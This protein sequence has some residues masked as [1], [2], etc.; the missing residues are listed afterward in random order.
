M[1]LVGE[2]RDRE[3]ISA[4]VTAAETGALVFATLHTYDAASTL[5]RI[6]S[7]YPEG[8]QDHIRSALAYVLRGVV[9]QTLLPALSGGRVAAYE[10]WLYPCGIKQPEGRRSA[11][12]AKL[13][14]AA[15]NT[16]C[17]TSKHTLLN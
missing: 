2:A 5:S 7:S 3:T 15:L 9:S 11:S 4:A 12:Y 1:I 8:E 13:S 10:G 14:P 16:E 17:K 6:V